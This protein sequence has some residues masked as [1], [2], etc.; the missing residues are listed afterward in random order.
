MP[1]SHYTNAQGELVLPLQ[2]L[3]VMAGSSSLNTDAI[4]ITPELARAIVALA[5]LAPKLSIPTVVMKGATAPKTM[6]PG[7]VASD[8]FAYSLKYRN[9]DDGYEF[10]RM[11]NADSIVIPAGGRKT[12]GI[13]IK[14]ALPPGYKIVVESRSGLSSNEGIEVGAGLIDNNY[15]EQIGVVLYNHSDRPFR[16]TGGDRIAQICVEAYVEGDWTPVDAL[17]PSNRVGGWGT[18]GVR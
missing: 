10:L 2:R 6:Q 12:F 15:R 17:P 11:G 5:G 9:G 1:A 18:S 16:V 3:P 14:V 7:D 8:V 13:G 4:A